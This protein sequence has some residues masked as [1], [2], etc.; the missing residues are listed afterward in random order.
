MK[1]AI[2]CR[3]LRAT[4]SGIPNFLVSA[5]NTIA[6]QNPNWQLYLLTNDDLNIELNNNLKKYSNIIFLIT[7]LKLVPNFAIIWYFLKVKSI[8]IKLDP[9]IFW[10]PAFLLP[11]LSLIKLK[12]LL[13]STTWFTKNTVKQCLF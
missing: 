10:A 9:D 13:Q 1:V 6:L 7:P 2:D 5:I 4:P 11:P 3:S 12:L 8:L